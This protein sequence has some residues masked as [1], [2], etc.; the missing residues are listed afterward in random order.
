MQNTPVVPLPEKQRGHDWY[1]LIGALALI[2]IVILIAFLIANPAGVV[3]APGASD[4]LANPELA[5]YHRYQVE[6]A[7][8]IGTDRLQE[9][10]ELAVFN[11]YQA[12]HPA[13]VDLAE[14]PEVG[15]FLR[16]QEDR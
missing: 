13:Q 7:A 4:A 6:H 14:N 12:T 10:P 8:A 1:P 5:A 16:W 9:N 15:V 2:L 3:Q 11:Y